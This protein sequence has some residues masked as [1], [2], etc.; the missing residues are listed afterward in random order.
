MTDDR[1][2]A[3]TRGTAGTAG[4]AGAEEVR[5]RQTQ[6]QAQTQIQA[7]AE[8]QARVQIHAPADSA[9]SARFSPY[10]LFRRGTLGLPALEDLTPRRT[11]PLLEE[12]ERARARREELR[13]Q[14]EDALHEAVPALAT[15]RRHEILRLRRDI[16]NDR[17][18][19]VPDAA[20][21]L[22]RPARELLEAWLRHRAEG[23]RLMK[24]A[25]ATLQAELDA[26]RRTLAA[27]TCQ[28]DFQR[29]LQLSDERTWRTVLD[30][31]ADP[32]S[33]RRKPSK[34]RRAENT[35]TSFAYRVVF[36]PSPFAS[37]TE[38]GAHPWTPE[39]PAGRTEAAPAAPKARPVQARLSSGLLSWMAYE[40]HRLDRA[41]ELMRI[42]LNN[43]LTAQDG[44]ASCIRRAPDG[45]EDAAFG[46]SRVVTARD[47]ALLRLL[48]QVLADGDQPEQGLLERELR[49]RLVTAGLA[50]DTAD[51][52]L[53]QLV[54]AGICHRGLGLPDQHPRPAQAIAQRLRGLGT[55]QAGRC[56]VVFERLQAVA[57]GFPAASAR[58][59]AALLAEVREQVDAFVAACGCRAPAPEAMRSVVYEDVGTREPARSWR[60]ELLEENRWAL[61]LFQRIV[62]VLDDASIEK[63]GLYAFFAREY[64]MNGPHG[65]APD[66]DADTDTDE[67]EGEGEGDAAGDVAFTEFY[68]AFAELPPAEA[69]AVAAGVGDPHSERLRRLRQEFAEL[70]RTELRECGDRAGGTGP[71][72][73]SGPSPSSGP[74][75]D[76]IRLDPARL[77]AFADRLPETL[78]PWRS[79]AYRVQFADGPHRRLAV[80][81][82]ITTG[83][84]V[85]F[86][87]FCEL[88]EPDR[89]D[90][91]SLTEALRDRIAE[92]TPRQCDITAVLGLN[93]NL[94]P[95]LSPYELVYPGS[96]PHTPTDRTHPNSHS[97]TLAD[98]AVRPDP[99][100]RVLTLVNV[101]DGQPLDLVPLNFLYPA[102]APAL[103]RLLCAFAP[104]RTYRGGLW[105]QLDRADAVAGLTTGRT[106]PPSA[107]RSRPRVL[108]GD[109]VLDRRSWRTPTSAVPAR[110]G[111]ER[112]EAAALAEFD[113]WRTERG[114]PRHT[115]F[116]V[117]APPAV[118][119]G[120]HDLLAETRRW[121]LEARSARLHKP[122]Y[123][124]ARNPFLLQVLARQ[125]AESGDGGTVTFVECL[126]RAEDY[127]G[128]DG[129]S[130]SA[131]E[132]FVELTL[133][134]A[135]HPA[136]P[137]TRGD[138]DHAHG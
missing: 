137:H 54:R 57:D 93:F 14:L 9:D 52:A 31:A 98:L 30:Y 1:E 28:E 3:E 42:R 107:E 128:R 33:P 5:E 48:R 25:E 100:R 110:D 106:G 21:L 13:G 114:I 131:E 27:T 103:Y 126:P 12:A 29:G 73:D 65:E 2:T 68:R 78:P 60:P 72:P 20:R 132:F 96:V 136:H 124:D 109:M 135:G 92:T 111:L 34:R 32:F 129:R 127:D 95:R 71:S 102:A 101:R 58:R 16:H 11:W 138:D 116:R 130:T 79:A 22:D 26:G 97:L 67:G 83:Q 94:H 113:R 19:G 122:H 53:D 24:E 61:E 99:A 112:Q 4:T 46:A 49:E 89:P 121:A 10:C 63:A 17:V 76:E 85:F 36:K 105:D 41:D 44:R 74:S 43:S 62:P 117:S 82:G 81:N 69:S 120:E 47:T 7:R 119:P 70:L 133:T 39:K 23:A 59:R 37:F 56:A 51:R 55:D 90:T 80:V 108:L 75:P 86:S 66:A 64:G 104:T 8:I 123:L 77:R 38:I 50:P 87:R 84:G 91:W 115:F 6:T 40:L 18:P 35:L 45:A 134:T 15:D 125:L 118:A 88:L